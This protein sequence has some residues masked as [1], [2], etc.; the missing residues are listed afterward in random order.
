MTPPHQDGVLDAAFVRD[1]RGRTVLKTLR[2]RFPLRTTVP[3]YVDD[4]DPAMAFLYVQNPTGAVF[5]HDR[6][7]TS[8]AAGDGTRVHVTTQSAT[9]RI[10]AEGV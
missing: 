8:V 9:K 2:Q 6:L 3:F 7:N 10:L 5:A 4:G 1:G